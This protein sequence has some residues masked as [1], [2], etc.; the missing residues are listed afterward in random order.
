VQA[1][2]VGVAMAMSGAIRDLVNVLWGTTEGLWGLPGVAMGYF[3]VYTLEITLLIIT[4]IA[5]LPLMRQIRLAGPGE[6]SPT[7]QEFEPAA[8]L[9]AARGQQTT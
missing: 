8:E 2:A 3:T 7:P 6:D 5:T 9:D 1:T 4:L